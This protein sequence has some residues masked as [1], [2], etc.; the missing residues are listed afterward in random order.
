MKMQALQKYISGHL[1]AL[2]ALAGLVLFYLQTYYVAHPT[3]WVS[4]VIG[5]LTVI[6]VHQVPN[7]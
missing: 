6:G 3:H 4:V 1:K 2:V 7:L 5:V